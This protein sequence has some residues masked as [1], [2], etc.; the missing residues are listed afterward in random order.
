MKLSFESWP[1]DP[2]TWVNNE[3]WWDECFL[4]CFASNVLKGHSHW[5]MLVGGPLCGKSVA[6]AALR[7][8]FAQEG[9]FALDYSPARWP[10]PAGKPGDNHLKQIMTLASQE[11][12]TFFAARPEKLEELSETQKEFLRWLIETFDGERAFKRWLDGLPKQQD[13]MLRTVEQKMLYT[14]QTVVLGI[15]GQIEEL[16]FLCRRVGFRQIILFVDVPSFLSSFQVIQLGD[17]FQWLELMHHDGL[18]CVSAVPDAMQLPEMLLNKARG[19]V[20]VIPISV[21][22]EQT[23]EITNRHI[24]AATGG[25]IQSL[26]DLVSPALLQQITAMLDDEFSGPVP[27][28][29]VQLSKLV[30]ETDRTNGSCLDEKQFTALRQNFYKKYLPLR[31]LS[32]TPRPGVWRGTRFIPLEIGHFELLQKM[33]QQKGRPLDHNQL[34]ISKENLHTLAH[35]IRLV[36]EPSPKEPIYLVN[37]RNE[38][39]WLENYL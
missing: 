24:R 25:N 38:G 22:F 27:G 21:S 30:L 37:Q 6:L 11:L 7:R 17:L 26:T 19:R 34:N 32:E 35:R 13:D 2:Y 10:Q 23:M 20:E 3:R 29:W 9:V 4:P 33:W 5:S 12:R 8:S 16:I 31:I 36:I 14:T 18:R 15:Q 28:A 1:F 39:Y